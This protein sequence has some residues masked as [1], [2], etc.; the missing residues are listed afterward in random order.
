ML[1]RLCRRAQ[2]ACRGRAAV[3]Y[4]PAVLL[5][6]LKSLRSPPADAPQPVAPSAAVPDLRYARGGTIVAF[7]SDS[8]GDAFKEGMLELVEPL[9]PHCSAVAFVDLRSAAWQRELAAATAAPV[10]FALGNFGAGELHQL[11]D[12]SFKSPWAAA[13]VPFVRLYGDVPAYYPQRHV[14]HF[15]NSINAYFHAEQFD[16][17]RRWFSAKAP[18]VFLP[19]FP[20]DCA[21]L[22]QVDVAAKIASGTVVFPKNGNAPE[23]LRD[24]WRT[25]LPATVAYALES[26]AEALSTHLDDDVDLAARVQQHYA[27]LDIDVSQNRRLVLF[28]VAQ[29]DD[30]LRRVK[31]TM[32]AESLLEMPVI[33]R[34]S[35]WDHLDF[36]GRRARYDPRFDYASTRELLDT[37]L[38][39][40]DMT[41]NTQRGPHDRVL[42]AAGRYS[43]FL[44]N[45]TRFFTH[46]FQNAAEFTFRFEPESIRACV[47]AALAR[48]R[49]TVETG[50]DLG[51]RMRELLTREHYAEPMLAVVD[52]CA[53]ACGARPE[54]T[55]PYVDFQPLP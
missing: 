48:P 42:R 15:E 6:L 44:T 12:G 54:G 17:F 25:G 36:N 26:L 40:L 24:Y 53:L 10:W 4:N 13:G 50:I 28:L 31:S 30:Y 43:A 5:S 1:Q 32:I 52:A 35:N 16:F 18:S 8:Q 19:L 38:A 29:L 3:A 41:P 9:R 21:P 7:F 39:M 14:Q 49:E 33:I 27:E 47:E 51:K 34:G 20:I 55:Q 46:S 45:R 22:D 23:R 11:P 2:L 37:T